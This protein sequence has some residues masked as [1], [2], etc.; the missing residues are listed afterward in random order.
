MMSLDPATR[1][2]LDFIRGGVPGNP[3]GESRGNYNAYYANPGST[4]DLGKLTLAEIDKFQKAMLDKGSVSTAIGGYQFI[5]STLRR[6]VEAHKVLDSKRFTPR[7]QDELAIFLM[8]DCGYPDWWQG[9][10]TD[11]E[12]LHNLSMQWASL[13]DPRNHGR[14]HYDRDA[15]GNHASTTMEKAI[16]MLARARALIA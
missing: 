2:I 9:K 13:P 14:S 4:F 3:D 15:A 7:F 10:L 8:L 1:V 6:L 12:F 5:R 11:D 16:E